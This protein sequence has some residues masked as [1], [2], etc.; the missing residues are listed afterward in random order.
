MKVFIDVTSSC[1]SGQNTGMQRMTRRIFAE[2]SQ[3]LDV[4]PI[5]WNTIGNFYVDLGPRE[6]RFLTRPFEGQ[7]KAA[8]R[9]EWRGEDPLTEFYRS[10]TRPRIN[11]E[12][13]IGDD[14]VFLVPDIFRDRRR[15]LLR[16]FLERTRARKVA[17][18]HDATDLRL[19][20][21]YPDREKKSRP[22]LESL[23]AFDLVICVSNEAQD[24]LRHY[25][26][27][28]GCRAPATVAEP[29][30]GELE[31]TRSAT[32]DDSR[33]DFV[34]YVS[35]FHAR[36]NHLGLLRAAQ[37]LWNDGLK[38]ELQLIGR[39]VGAPLNKIVRAIWKL[40]MRGRSL[41]WLRHVNDQVLLNAY[42]DCRFTVYPSLMEGY[43]LPIVESLVHGKPCICGGNGA[44]GEVARGGGCLIVDQTSAGALAEG[45]K[46]LLL[47]QQLYSRLSNEARARKFRSWSDYIDKFLG[48]LDLLRAAS[49]AHRSKTLK[50]ADRGDGWQ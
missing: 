29:W 31:N 21:V 11:L 38:F 49:A 2:L 27:K 6:L 26:N 24:D 1:R 50:S 8:A 17:I 16:S 42:R 23:A 25:W 20:G 48:H 14:D 45:I 34:L 13:E 22:Y 15:E 5:S 32:A 33:E 19:T 3:Q 35:T 30:P 40:R 28:F 46:M 41:R 9:P 37:Q 7:A 10:L 4:R 43:G 39:N 18:F 47:D 36:K 12:Q 44:L